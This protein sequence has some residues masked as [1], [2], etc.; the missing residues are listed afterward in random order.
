[1]IWRIRSK[2]WD[3]LGMPVYRFD[4]PIEFLKEEDAIA[5]LQK[6][7]RKI[8]RKELIQSVTISAT[9]QSFYQTL[10]ITKFKRKVQK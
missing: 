4:K 2:I 10:K 6:I 5:E 8:G 3:L 1:L 7:Y 9:G